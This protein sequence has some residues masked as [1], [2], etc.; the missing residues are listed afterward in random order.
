MLFFDK[1]ALDFWGEVKTVQTE[2]RFFDSEVLAVQ[3]LD[4]VDATLDSPHHL[5]SHRHG[6]EIE[7]VSIVDVEAV[8]Q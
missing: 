4:L 3:V 5:V 6:A 2:H 7:N 1:A 8:D